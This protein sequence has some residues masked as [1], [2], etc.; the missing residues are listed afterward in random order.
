MKEL[1]KNDLMG[2]DGGKVAYAEYTWSGTDNPVVYVV[3][4]AANGVKLLYNAAA[5]IRN[6]FGD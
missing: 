3:E 6:F 1:E 5:A 4:A 2:I